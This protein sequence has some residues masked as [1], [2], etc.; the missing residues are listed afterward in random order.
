MGR[1]FVH[2]FATAVALFVATKVVPGV[3]MDPVGPALTLGQYVVNLGLI[4]IIFG[5]VN[6][7]IRPLIKA[8]TCLVNLLTLGLFTFVING[9]MLLITSAIA[10]SF[11]LGFHVD[12]FLAAIEG[13]I[14]VGVMSFIFG[15]LIPDRR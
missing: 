8:S 2:L 15:F 11:K 5:L 6:A 13:A 7:I 9:V 10:Q 14:V 3:R 12:G 1:F 4:A